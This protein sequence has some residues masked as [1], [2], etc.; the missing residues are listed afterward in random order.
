M[1][2]IAAS[3]MLQNFISMSLFDVMNNMLDAWTNWINSRIRKVYVGY[4]REQR[5]S[6]LFKQQDDGVLWFSC[7]I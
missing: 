3:S 6:I 7:V 4:Q 5:V 1:K 2:D